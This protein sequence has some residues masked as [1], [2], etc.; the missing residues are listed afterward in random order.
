MEETSKTDTKFPVSRVKKI[1]KSDPEVKYISTDTCFLISKATEMFLQSLA[2]RAHEECRKEGRS[3]LK[4]QDIATTVRGSDELEFLSDIIPL[5]QS[6][7]D[8]MKGN[9][10]ITDY[11]I[12][13]DEEE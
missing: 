8:I 10:R 4:Y 1:I 12:G 5:Q 2:R 6:S 7:T 11:A 9:R 13:M 3:T